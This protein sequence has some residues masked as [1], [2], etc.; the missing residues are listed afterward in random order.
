MV[1]YTLWIEHQSQSMIGMI[2]GHMKECTK[3][4]KY[5]PIVKLHSLIPE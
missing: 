1:V 2:V 5:L 4:G 3:H